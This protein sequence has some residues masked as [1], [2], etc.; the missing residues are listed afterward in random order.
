MTLHASGVIGK[1]ESV[2]VQRE[3]KAEVQLNEYE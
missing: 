3:R 1:T 2:Q